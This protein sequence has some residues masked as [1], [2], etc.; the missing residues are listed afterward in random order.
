MQCPA[1]M[2]PLIAKDGSPWTGRYGEPC[3]GHDDMETG[4]CPWWSMACAVGG[5][6]Q[7]VEEAAAHGGQHVVAG[8]NKVRRLQDET[9][10][11]YDCPK[12]SVCRWQERATIE[13]RDLCPPRDA[14]R[15]GLDPRVTL[16]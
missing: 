11:E 8:P 5:V 6:Q 12:A 14:L 1:S 4:G 7:Q 10:R 2:C 16:F 15:R 3:P 9:S 13:G